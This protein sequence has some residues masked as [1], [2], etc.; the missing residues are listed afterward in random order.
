MESFLTVISMLL[1]GYS[2]RF[3]GGKI[4]AMLTACSLTD[5]PKDLL[6]HLLA[7]CQLHLRTRRYPLNI[8]HQDALDI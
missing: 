7:A 5:E 8:K 1:C 2:L 3:G 4:E 6:S